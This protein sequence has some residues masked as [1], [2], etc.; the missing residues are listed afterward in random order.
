M[1]V[2][3]PTISAG[4]LFDD[5]APRLQL[6]WV[7]GKVGR[8]RLLEHAAGDDDRPSLAG[9]LNMVHPSSL[10][11]LGASELRYL[12]SLDSRKR[13]ETIA[14]I[15]A[16]RPVAL[17]VSDGLGVPDDLLESANESGT[18]LWASPLPGI[19]LVNVVLHELGRRM[20]RRTTVHG[21]F[22]EVF[23]IGVLITGAAGTGKS[24]LALEL[25]TRGHRLIAD[26]APEMTL[27]APDVIDGTCPPV[28]QDCLEV[29]G[30]GILNIRAMFG[31]S[32]IKSNKYLRL[33]LNL[34]IAN[35]PV[36]DRTPPLDRLRGDHSTREILGM[37]V[38]VVTIPV[39]PGR[40]I[41]VIVEAA[42]RNHNLRLRGYDSSE[43]FLA[44]HS[45]F[46]QRGD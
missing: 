15:F 6:T 26:D 17:M 19:D 20:A 34:D 8:K 45:E 35:G 22:M 3:T 4:D 18:P 10:Q 33:I 25:I 11:V 28:L 16:R 37:E 46:V 7:A 30:L 23:S 24:E 9:F 36:D 14:E 39:A 42:V 27:I 12:D 32:A 31:D 29:R 5:L 38:P 40:N 41:A 43:E 21:V 1:T 2:S 13:W 44:R